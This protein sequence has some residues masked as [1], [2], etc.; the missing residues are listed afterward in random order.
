MTVSSG[1][2]PDSYGLNECMHQEALKEVEDYVKKIKGSWA[3]TG[4]SIVMDAWVDQKGRDL[5]IFVA[6]SPAGPVYLK[7]FDVSDIK[8]NVSALLSLVDGLVDEVGVHN[9]IQIVACSTYGWVGE[10]GEY[11]A[12]NKNEFFWSVSVSHCFELMLRRIA[13]ICSLGDIV[14]DVNKMTRFINNNPLVLELVRNHSHGKHMTVSSSEFEFV[15]PYITL[16]SI[17]KAKNDLAAMF[18]SSDWNKEEDITISKLVNDSSFWETVGKI[19]KCTSPLISSLHWLSAANNQHVGIIYDTMDCIKESIAME[20]NDDKRCYMPL[21]DVIDD[22]WNRHLHSPLHAAGYFLNPTTFYST[23]FLLDS[24]VATG[25]ISSLVH[26]VKECQVQV[27]VATQLDTYR[28]GEDCFNEADQSPGISPAEW[29]AQKAS[30][31]PELQSFAIKILSQTCEDA[32]RYKLERSFAEKMLLTEG[33][34]HSERKHL[35]ELTFVH[36]NLHLQSCNVKLSEELAF[37]H[38]NLHL[39]SCKAK[40]SKEQ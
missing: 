7:S 25:L 20:L 31:H 12:S 3:V 21:W 35:E 32:S 23:D 29:W 15:M 10:L 36:Y 9:V 34:S 8:T 26:V 6:D 14:D 16:E 17:F 27:Q 13:R 22:V 39:R 40:L 11:F 5:V 30:Q 38:N 28:L 24:E 1:K 37:A 19:L 2:I 33:M 4:C 18:A